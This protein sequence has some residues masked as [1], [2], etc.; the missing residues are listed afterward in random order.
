M[1]HFIQMGK[2]APNSFAIFRLPH[3]QKPLMVIGNISEKIIDYALLEENA[4]VISPFN[5]GQ[6]AFSIPF[7]K[8]EEI[9]E[10]KIPSFH[11]SQNKYT[12]LGEEHY[13]ETVEKGIEKLHAN[14]LSKVVLAN[15]KTIKNS[16]FEPMLY[17]KKLEE[18]YPTAFIYFIS[19]PQTGTWFGAS[20]EPL[21]RTENNQLQTVAMAGTLA[22]TPQAIWSN[23]ER[24]EQAMVCQY[25]E[26]KLSAAALPFKKNGPFNY[27][28]GALTH[29]RT[30]YFCEGIPSNNSMAKFIE[31][32][33]PTPAVAG[34]PK[35]EAI[36]FIEKEEGFKRNLY[37][38]F[39]GIKQYNEAQLFVNIRCMEWQRETLTLFAGAG[40]TKDSNPQRE[41]EETKNKMITME[42]LINLHND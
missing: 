17:F 11:F 3:A 23:K 35:E 21:V 16:R 25:L 37:A 33:N 1:C 9:D 22:Q 7:N 26:D 4:I 18:K 38:G 27:A 28:A 36:Q 39:I 34:I 30:E 31:E 40:I 6:K 5:C 29:L 14:K 12:A 32:I 24:E 2:E 42:A 20:P 41:W 10:K 13:I 8:L 19:S 15:T